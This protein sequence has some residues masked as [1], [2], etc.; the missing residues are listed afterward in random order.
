MD[1]TDAELL[2]PIDVSPM[3]P[4]TAALLIL[5]ATGDDTS[6][7]TANKESNAAGAHVANAQ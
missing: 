1:A 3:T 2:L 6:K 4:V 5:L 7:G